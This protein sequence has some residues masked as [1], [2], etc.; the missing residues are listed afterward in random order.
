MKSIIV[1]FL[2][3]AIMA[4][5]A[6]SSAYAGEVV[7]AGVT[8][9]HQTVNG[10]IFIVK[11]VVNNNSDKTITG[12]RAYADRVYCEKAKQASEAASADTPSIAKGG[13]HTVTLLVPPGDEPYL[14]ISLR[15]DRD[16][17]SYAEVTIPRANYDSKGAAIY[18][19]RNVAKPVGPATTI[20]KN[21]IKMVAPKS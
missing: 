16:P 11:F 3:V 8:I 18:G 2:A 20:P 15:Q 7:L 5:F 12:A 9:T 17:E 13:S 10:E 1:R 19:C 14:R 6:V 4:G 21:K